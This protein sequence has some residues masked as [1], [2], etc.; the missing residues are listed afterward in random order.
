MN[1]KGLTFK[2][3]LF[4]MVVAGMMITAIGVSIGEWGIKYNS[5]ITYDLQEYSAQDNL[6]ST[7]DSQKN[8][9]T[10]QDPDPGSGADFESKLFRGGYGILG[11]IFTPF[12]P[13][14][15]MLSSLEVRFGIPKYILQGIT[16][17]IFF[18][19]ITA[20]IAVLFRLLRPN[21]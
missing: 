13:F 17:L 5:G 11:S 3:A 20:I 12:N 14:F 21:V 1:K 10:P 4:A 6:A 15:N 19:F 7:A 8:Q 9:I 16:A 18:A 2:N